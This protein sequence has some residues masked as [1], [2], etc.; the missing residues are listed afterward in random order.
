MRGVSNRLSLLTTIWSVLPK[1]LCRGSSGIS[2]NTSEMITGV[3]EAR[4]NEVAP[5]A[6]RSRAVGSSASRTVEEEV[7]VDD[8]SKNTIRSSR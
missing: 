5:M 1:R 6:M 3:K 8:S 2:R 4:K 7:V